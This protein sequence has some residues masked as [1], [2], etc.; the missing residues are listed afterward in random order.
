M[1]YKSLSVETWNKLDSSGNKVFG[2]KSIWLSRNNESSK[3][4]IFKDEMGGFHFAIEATN[5]IN[6]EDP[7]I[8]GLNLSFNQ[9]C[10]GAET[11]K[12][13]IDIRCDLVGYLEE[14]TE[15]IKE[16]TRNILENNEKP[17]EVVIRTIRNWKSFW[18]NKNILLLSEEQLIGLM[19]ELKVLQRLILIHNSNAL[20]SWTGPLLEKHDFIFT[21]WCFEVKGTRTIEIVH[22]INGIDQL[23]PPSNKKLGFISFLISYAGSD[24]SI[25]LPSI[26]EDIK[27]SLGTRPE[28]VIQFN[29]LLAETGY[30]PM[31]DEE[32]KKFKI[33][34]L[35]SNLFIVDDSF[36]SFTSDNLKEP[37]NSRITSFRYDISL[38][39]LSGKCF[40]KI[41]LGEYFY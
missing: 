25:T 9:Y 24:N 5:E 28:L 19:C 2:Y 13:F 31:H 3:L 8:N 23:K 14:F 16:I 32:Y 22:T 41:N 30:S 4:H 20:R 26:I 35:E 29:D 40:D 33:E 36:P 21:D 27:S 37:L 17:S 10:L 11:I 18:A 6:I 7:R 39:G 1:D 15:V 34:F 38:E 12:S